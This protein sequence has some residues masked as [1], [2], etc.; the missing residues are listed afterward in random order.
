MGKFED[1]QV[2][3]SLIKSFEKV[4]DAVRK[5]EGRSRAGLMLGLQ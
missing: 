3:Q 2:E 5:S 1:Y 4:K